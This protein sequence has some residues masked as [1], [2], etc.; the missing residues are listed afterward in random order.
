[1]SDEFQDDLRRR[2]HETA[3]RLD[4]PASLWERFRRRLA[5][6]RRRPALM[7][8][9][10]VV[11]LALTVAVANLAVADHGDHSRHHLVAGPTATSAVP[12]E[13]TTT[14]QAE[15]TTTPPAGVV[16]PVTVPSVPTTNR[17]PTTPTTL[18]A[19][20]TGDL[21]STT[22]T[23]RASYPPGVSVE[24]TLIVR[25]VSRH[26]CEYPHGDCPHFTVQD[27]Y[28][29]EVWTSQGKPPYVCPVPLRMERL[30]AGGA[31]RPVTRTWDRQTCAP[32]P[33]T[34]STMWAGFPC[35]DGAA[36]AGTY[37]TTG[38]PDWI[39]RT[40]AG[41]PGGDVPVKEST[42]PAFRLE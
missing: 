1:M 6:R 42:S 38:Y 3:S 27:S 24:L 11:A 28:G 21:R 9:G 34:T 7:V 10:G 19:C 17:R 26:P 39:D 2:L 16:A 37:T 15:T 31:A 4:P 35:H 5:W 36:S 25:N 41:Y 14:S 32:P 18:P 22:S 33:T 23:D 12:N 40:A 20:N 8:V 30:E 13:E 29:N